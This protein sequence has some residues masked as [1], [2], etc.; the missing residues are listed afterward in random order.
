[1]A[2]PNQIV[3]AIDLEVLQEKANQAAME[4][5]IKAIEKYYTGFDSPYVKGVRESLEKNRVSYRF[6]LPDIV[7]L[8]NDKLESE[9][10]AIANKAIAES[11]IPLLRSVTNLENKEMKFSRILH[12]FIDFHYGV[13]EEDFECEI[14]DDKD[15]WIS[16]EL[17]ADDKKYSF[18]LGQTYESKKEKIA[19][20]YL[21]SL[22]DADGKS[23]D[24]FGEQMEL[25]AGEVTLKMPFTR[26]AINHPFMAFMASVIISDC[27]ITMDVDGFDE[28]MF[29]KECHC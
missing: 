15:G 17:K 5:A 20:Y 29:E 28:D 22:P 24:T 26:N 25:S 23:Y 14:D 8:I 19:R 12:Q 10:N 18:R 16:I 11:F 27:E 3:P 7:A 2:Q 6:D 13:E 1:M 21:V 9:M 4:G